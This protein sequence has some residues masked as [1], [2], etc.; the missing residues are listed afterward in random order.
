MAAE[1][2][3]RNHS[4]DS[5]HNGGGEHGRPH[6]HATAAGHQGHPATAEGIA[7]LL[8]EERRAKLPP[9]ETLRAAGVAQGQTVVDLGC[10]P[11]YFT[12]PAAE[13]VGP[14]GKVYGVDVQPEMVEACQQ[15]AAEAGARQ[16]EVLQPT[17]THVP[18][19]DGIADLVL[20]SVVLHEAKDRVAFLREARRLLKAGGAVAVI[21][22]RKEA[23][24]PGPPKEVRLSEA[25]VAAA[26]EAAGMRVRERRELD[27]LHMLFHL[28]PTNDRI[29]RATMPGNH[30]HDGAATASP[31]YDAAGGPSG[32]GGHPAHHDH[33]AYAAHRL[34]GGGGQGA[35]GT[36]AGTIKALGRNSF[37]LVSK[38]GAVAVTTNASTNFHTPGIAQAAKRAGYH[39]YH[40]LAFT[41]LK[42][43]QRVGVMG[44]WQDD[45]ML[46]AWRVH[47][48]KP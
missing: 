7:A 3:L 13:L 21:E 40:E 35:T 39:G 41:A 34:H 22:F 47:I 4:R 20:A 45:G 6:Q 26:A 24:A 18:L 36:I 28:A 10:G 42:V 8:S 11:G 32:H 5:G 16:I 37:V 48:S 9:E 31:A 25:E 2:Q 29:E 44:E 23:E 43:G 33:R 46:V 19:P 14:H 38:Q 17:E 1:R 12:L 15:R 30:A 27:D